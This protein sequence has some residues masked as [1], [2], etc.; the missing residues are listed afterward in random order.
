MRNELLTKGYGM[1][2]VTGATGNAGGA[3]VRALAEAGLPVRGL[4]R[5]PAS[6]LPPGVEEVVGNLHQPETFIESLA[7]TTGLFLLSGYDGTQRLLSAASDAGVRHVVLL[8]SNSLDGTDTT[9]AISSYHLASEQAV[10]ES[11]LGWSFLRPTSFMANALRWS[12]QLGKGD[13]VRVQFPEV[14]IAT[15]DPRDIAD[16]AVAAFT[17]DPQEDRIYRLTGPVALTPVEQVTI[18]G[19]ALGRP[20]EP[21]AMTLEETRAALD[22]SMPAPYADAIYSFFGRGTTDETTVRLTVE[23]VTGHPARTF[24]QW[25]ADNAGRFPG[26]A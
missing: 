24:E 20:L 10:R 14:P 18:L 13:V 3:V 5:R 25:C 26:V 22:A 16:V 4:V 21:Y 2:L 8:S 19:N 15:I 17:A 12:D 9:N 23:E 1:F 7:G 6:G 11:G